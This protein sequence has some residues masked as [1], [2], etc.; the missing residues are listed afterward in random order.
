MGNENKKVVSNTEPSVFNK[1]IKDIK[2]SINRAIIFGCS[3]FAIS[4]IIFYNMGITLKQQNETY[5]E[6]R[7]LSSAVL[8]FIKKNSVIGKTQLT[9]PTNPR[10]IAIAGSLS[11][12]DIKP[13]TAKIY[14]S[15]VSKELERDEVEEQFFVNVVS[16]GSPSAMVESTGPTKLKIYDRWTID[17]G[18]IDSPLLTSFPRT[19]TLLMNHESVGFPKC[20]E[21]KEPFLMYA[22]ATSGVLDW[23]AEP[24]IK[25]DEK[26]KRWIVQFKDLKPMDVSAF[27]RRLMVI[28][29]C[30]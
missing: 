12:L 18:S 14:L 8:P 28:T 17:V 29:N 9:Y 19:P 10:A 4:L 21:G 16:F 5:S 3:A 25:K 11:L 27:D 15:K 1:D 30:K 7:V 6:I 23:V 2:S 22:K 20:D 26:L 13:S 24:E